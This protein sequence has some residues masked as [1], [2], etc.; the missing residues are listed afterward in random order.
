MGI[1]RTHNQGSGK[2]AGDALGQRAGTATQCDE[3]LLG[4]VLCAYRKNAQPQRVIPRLFLEAP[5]G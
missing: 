5:C 3:N 1:Q 2:G 4:N